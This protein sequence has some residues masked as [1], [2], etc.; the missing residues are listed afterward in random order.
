ME[1]E[2]EVKIETGVE[3]KGWWTWVGFGGDINN[4]GGGYEWA[5]GM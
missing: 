2:T 4:G 1:V 5:G 3:L